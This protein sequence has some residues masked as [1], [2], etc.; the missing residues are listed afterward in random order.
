MSEVEGV[1]AGSKGAPPAAKGVK[2]AE[3]KDKGQTLVNGYSGDLGKDGVRD[4]KKDLGR[5]FRKDSKDASQDIKKDP[6]KDYRR[7]S[8]KEL[9][10][11]FSAKQSETAPMTSPTSPTDKVTSPTSP[12]NKI[13]SPTT[14]TDRV[15]A[16]RFQ[17]ERSSRS[18]STPGSPT[19]SPSS[20]LPKAH[21]KSPLTFSRASAKEGKTSDKAE[22][23]QREGS[24]VQDDQLEKTEKALKEL[25][26]KVM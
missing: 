17:W 24:V 18:P 7:S 2:V 23:S 3:V 16:G 12:T 9:G 26:A 14:P 20:P 15:T 5:D 6:G 13:T 19:S 25:Q 1:A 21:E 8:V 4:A 22:A 11:T 10:T